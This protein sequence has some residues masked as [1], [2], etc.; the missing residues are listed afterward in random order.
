MMNLCAQLHFGESSTGNDP[1]NLFGR[2]R[3]LERDVP[4]CDGRYFSG[5]FRTRETR[6]DMG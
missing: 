5:K 4:E 2:G 3:Y 1:G 6:M